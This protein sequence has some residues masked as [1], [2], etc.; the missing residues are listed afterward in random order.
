ME[1]D[2]PKLSLENENTKQLMDNIFKS[3]IILSKITPSTEKEKKS[4]W[5]ELIKK[6]QNFRNL[7]KYNSINF[8]SQLDI[9]K[10]TLKV[11]FF[12]HC[13]S[14]NDQKKKDIFIEKI[15]S[16]LY[17]S[18]RSN[19]PALINGNNDTRNG[20]PNMFTSD[21][22]WGCMIRSSQM[23]LS[24]A[25]Y[26]LFKR[27]YPSK[28]GNVLLQCLFYFFDYPCNYKE[29]P[30]SFLSILAQYNS[31]IRHG[32]NQSN[33]KEKCN[34]ESVF[35][36]FSLRTICLV[37]QLF[38]KRAGMWFSDF[39]L[40]QI[41]NLI[42]REFDVI[43]D[44]SII[45]FQGFINKRIVIKECFT[46]IKPITD[47]NRNTNT[48][49]IDINDIAFESNITFLNKQYSYTKSGLIFISTRLGL[50]KISPDYYDSL[51]EVFNCKQFI[52]FIGGKGVMAYYFFGYDSNHLLY[53]D[54]HFNQKA[55]PNI[56]DELLNSYLPKKIYQL[57]FDKLQTCLTFAFLFRDDKEYN[58]LFEWLNK[59]SQSTNPCFT[60]VDG[61]D[62]DIVNK[63]DIIN[64]D[65]DDF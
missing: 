22:G 17:F 49:I 44:L 43:P 37:G 23:V 36:P 26:K 7:I 28:K 38:N 8:K 3:S 25:L 64:F 47:T 16:L 18:Y 27:K 31:N 11:N 61:V 14:L 34:I 12:S 53:L 1:P 2:C 32:D 20:M 57:K 55:S 42:N 59:Y 63:D 62:I 60:V 51:K 56:N 24:R 10:N 48:N 50:E 6:F 35:P 15:S 45:H 40:P 33:E 39:H 9:D 13:N 65:K 58:M 54:P 52:G 5:K 29:L 41:F 4:M 19:F 21:C 30:D 46:Q